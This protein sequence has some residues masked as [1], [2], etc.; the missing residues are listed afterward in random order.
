MQVCSIEYRFALALAPATVSANSCGAC[1]APGVVDTP[2]VWANLAPDQV[3]HA[4]VDRSPIG[5][6]HFHGQAAPTLFLLSPAASYIMARCRPSIVAAALARLTAKTATTWAIVP[7]RRRACTALS[8][9]R[10]GSGGAPAFPPQEARFKASQI[11]ELRTGSGD[12]PRRRMLRR[13]KPT[14]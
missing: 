3:Q 6:V 5:P 1:F 11:R 8:I 2:P 12:G 7:C 14:V 9:D 13:L 4:M 10:E